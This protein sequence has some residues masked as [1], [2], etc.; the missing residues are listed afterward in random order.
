MTVFN[1]GPVIMESVSA[2]TATPSIEVGT[3]YRKGDEQYIYVYNAGNSQISPGFGATV[4][5]VS[6]YSVTVSTVTSTD[7]VVGVCQHATLTTATYGWLLT[8]GFGQVSMGASD[9]AAAGGLLGV[10]VDGAF[11]L[12][13]SATGHTAP[14]F[15]KAMAAI[16]SGVSGTA[17]IRCG[18]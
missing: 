8:T 10:A 3:V 2:V 15:A 7:F 9:S 11:C 1:A 16:A 17:F 18:F 6:G 4:S 14:A 5:G 13:S 12:Q